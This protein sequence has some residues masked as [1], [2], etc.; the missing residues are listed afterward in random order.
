MTGET[1]RR[2]L[3]RS[4]GILAGGLLAAGATGATAADRSDR[5]TDPERASPET[6]AKLV[7]GNTDF[8]ADLHRQLA[9]RTGKANLLASPYSVSSAIAM[10]YAG[11]RN[12]T[13]AEMAEAMA[14]RL[15]GER[16]HRGFYTLNRTLERRSEAGSGSEE[17]A[18]KTGEE[19]NSKSPLECILR[20][21]GCEELIRRLVSG[22]TPALPER[23]A[24]PGDGNASSEEGPEGLTIEV[25]NAIWGQEGAPFA[26]DY[27]HTLETY[28]GAGLKEVDFENSR[29]KARERINGWTS[30][31]TEG[32][33]EQIL[34][35]GSLSKETIAVLTNAI[36]VNGEW[37]DPFDEDRT[38]EESFTAVDG[39]ETDVPT[40]KKSDEM[41]YASVDGHQVVDLPYVGGKVSMTVILPAKGEYESFRDSLTGD[42]LRS[43]VEGLS[44]REGHLELPKFTYRSKAKLSTDLKAMDM[45]RAF[46]P[47]RADLF[48]MVDVPS[49]EKA[50]NHV[51][52]QEVFH[53]TFVEVD[54]R[55]AE[56]A[57]ATA[58]TVGFTS[59]S[60][61][62][63]DLEPFE[64]IVDRPFVFA[65]RDR[66][67]GTVLFLGQVGDAG[68]AA[69]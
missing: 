19:G 6:V 31:R 39:S 49:R 3:L 52:I 53:K 12:E 13:R 8:A 48:G 10:V 41:S 23:P 33:I 54:E 17:T 45:K 28:Y 20:G 27:L 29:A 64:M 2:R 30:D 37:K 55:G 34:P 59:T 1:T 58:V 35:K 7:A 46:D 66:E 32:R 69:P 56:A 18:T 36:Y 67:T 5:A 15:D 24:E 65:I 44:P 62:G 60:V 42:R 16:L 4:G 57:G 9:S 21:E 40:M 22:T 47:D 61:G 63:P 38:E 14:Y 11:A 51:W 68:A 50:Q 26:E 43:M 25:A